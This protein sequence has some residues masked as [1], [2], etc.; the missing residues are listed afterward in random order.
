MVWHSYLLNPRCFFEDCYRL[1]KMDF[2]TTGWPWEAVDRCIDIDT[3][4]FSPPVEAQERFQGSTAL[5]WKNEDDPSNFQMLCLDPDCGAQ[6]VIPWTK[7]SIFSAEQPETPSRGHG[8]CDQVFSVVCGKCGLR[9]NHETLRVHKFHTDVENLVNEDFPLPGTVLSVS[10]QPETKADGNGHPK[11]LFPTLL[12]QNTLAAEFTASTSISRLRSRITMSSVKSVLEEALNDSTVIKRAR[13]NGRPS[14][15]ADGS[16]HSQ[17]RVAVRR[18]MS[19]YWFNS[20]PFAL[21]LDG[22]VIRQ[23]KS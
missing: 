4:E 16:L 14:P 17:E 13:A 15:D 11:C 12:V 19:R 2:Y 10:G 21:D 3:F 1:G 5:S 6:L 9:V 7:D 8:F 23:G 18:M 20:S 22:A